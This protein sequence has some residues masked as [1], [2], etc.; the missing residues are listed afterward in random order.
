MFVYNDEFV[1]T[2]GFFLRTETIT[3]IYTFCAGFSN[4]IVVI[5]NYVM[6]TYAKH[7]ENG[8][9]A[10]NPNHTCPLKLFVFVA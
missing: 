4:H 6:P 1:P 7:K 2:A 10:K 5:N 8:I 9:D 3:M